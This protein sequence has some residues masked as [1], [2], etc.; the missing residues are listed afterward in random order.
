MPIKVFI[1]TGR[2]GASGCGNMPPTNGF[3]PY[4]R[5]SAVYVCPPKAEDQEQK[6]DQ[7]WHG[8]FAIWISP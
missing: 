4:N 3:C 2:V 1:S 5:S 7:I 6:E 8:M